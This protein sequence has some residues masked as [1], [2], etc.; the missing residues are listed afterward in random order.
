MKGLKLPKVPDLASVNVLV[1]ATRA[2]LGG[3][4][5]AAAEPPPAPPPTGVIVTEESSAAT[6]FTF[7]PLCCVCLPSCRRL[8][9]AVTPEAGVFR[10]EGLTCFAAD[11][12]ESF[13][14]QDVVLLRGVGGGRRGIV[15]LAFFLASALV[16][17]AAALSVKTSQEGTG[18]GA[19]AGLFLVL[20]VMWLLMRGSTL[21]ALTQAAGEHV[22]APSDAGH[23]VSPGELDKVLRAC[24]AAWT[25]VRGSP[26]GAEADPSVMCPK[27]TVGSR[28]ANI[29]CGTSEELNARSGGLLVVQKMKGF[30]RLP[31]L[32]SVDTCAF[33]A[34][35]VRYTILETGNRTLKG[36]QFALLP[37]ALAALLIRVPQICNSSE[38]APCTGPIAGAVVAGL[39]L[40]IRWFLSLKVALTMN[41][42]DPAGLQPS[43]MLPSL[44]CA[45][46]HKGVL[47]AMLGEPVEAAQEAQ[48]PPLPTVN[49]VGRESTGSHIELTVGPSLTS[50]KVTD[51]AT[52]SMQKFLC[53]M[54]L[55]ST[56][57]TCR[58]SDL[59]FAST[60]RTDLIN[61]LLA[62]L[63][64]SAAVIAIAVI[65]NSR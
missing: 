9:V 62:S 65:V 23:G 22:L 1:S 13:A 24:A 8:R 36:L 28:V 4:K 3:G 39:L 11:A 38:A 12:H 19:G 57:Y 63:V 64:A 16:G 40:L 52:S 32:T 20:L 51:G 7:T 21:R 45:A 6:V 55:S 47:A 56:E 15:L 10:S 33:Y 41:L 61:T 43:V 14:W 18:V 27:P 44:T 31:L 26:S 58:T 48:A 42:G 5:K 35:S 59:L 60:S 54:C 30:L 17:V 29:F 53:Q 50:I 46:A 2:R 34:S 25:A 49:I 37:L